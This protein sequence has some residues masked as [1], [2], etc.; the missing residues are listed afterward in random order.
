MACG[1]VLEVDA[2]ICLKKKESNL[3]LNKKGNNM[4]LLTSEYRFVSAIRN[5]NLVLS[6]VV[7][8]VAFK[9]K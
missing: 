2:F 9:N 7:P 4:G 1:M 5:V 8:N 3:R 6:R